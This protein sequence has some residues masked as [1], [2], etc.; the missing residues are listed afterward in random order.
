M[1]KERK[2]I[3]IDTDLGADCDD[4]VALAL[5]I[6]LHK[7]NVLNVK[8]ITISSTREF[9]P[10]TLSAI[11]DYY[12][13][14]CP[15]GQMGLP[16]IDV[17]KDD[18]YCFH[19]KDRLLK[20]EIEDSVKLLRKTLVESKDKVIIATLGPLTNIARL[21][22]SSGDELSPL[23]GL[24]LINSK[25]ESIYIMGGAFANNLP[26]WNLKSD[27][28]S[29]ELVLKSVNVPLFFLPSECG[30]H[31]K[32]GISLLKQI[33]SPV[34][35]SIKSF[36]ESNGRVD[37]FSR[38]S[39]DPLT[40]LSITG[41]KNINVNK[42]GIVSIDSDGVTTL[43]EGEGEHHILEVINGKETE[44][45]INDHILLKVRGKSFMKNE[46]T[47]S[48]KE[49]EIQKRNNAKVLSI[50]FPSDIDKNDA[51]NNYIT[52][53]NINKIYDNDV[54]AVFDF[55]LNINKNEFIVL[56]GPSGCG[57]ST[58]LRMIAGLEEISSGE[59]FINSVY[60]NDLA[61]KNRDIAMVFQTYALYPHMTVYNNLAFGIKIRKF[62][63]PVLDKEGHEVLWIDKREIKKINKQ[64]KDCNEIEKIC[65][66]E[67]EKLK[68]IEGDEDDKYIANKRINYYEKQKSLAEQK[69]ESLEKD[70][71]KAETTMVPKCVYKHLKK[72]EID[73]RVLEAAKILEID[74]YLNRKPKAL[75]GGQRQRV[76]LGRA[77]VRNSAA[78][79]MDEPLS[80]LDAKLRVQ[81]R[82]EI[83]N[84][85]R[86]VGATTIYVTHDQTEAMTMAD[87]IVVMKDGMV[88]QI[89]TPIDIYSHPKNLFVA[90]FIGAPAMNVIEG[91]FNGKEVAFD[92]N[93]QELKNI[94]GKVEEYY[95]AEIARLN[96]V[97]NDME[98]M[99]RDKKHPRRQIFEMARDEA[100]SLINNYQNKIDTMSFDV[101]LGIRPEDVVVVDKKK[102]NVFE[103]K[104][105]MVELLGSEY[106]IH[107]TFAG[108]KFI[109]KTSNDRVIK[110]GDD[111]LIEFKSEKI[112]LFD[113]DSKMSIF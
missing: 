24:E 54:Q 2:N 63:T 71:E 59:L 60:S 87:R 31:I 55:N 9:A 99:L 110:T 50:I 61:A 82:S 100:I 42:K 106:F 39:W 102:E 108:Q 70:L 3:I 111:V 14:D 85:H 64:I 78:F 56:V 79:L 29:A 105:D 11:M 53:K 44:K 48:K 90:Q 36:Y 52:L 93:K 98:E 37:E 112:H 97:K 88:Q 49:L 86:K 91:Q 21:I 27:I 19:F 25:V 38:E 16:A 113:L 65:D 41:Y 4:C 73:K 40:I 23:N 69:R 34:Y 47:I 32:T 1:I 84:I 20:R 76:A 104:A 103:V 57:K 12:H 26:E 28:R 94:K 109:F 6:N 75:S 58:T 96:N 51:G 22:N 13:F 74:G 35:Q 92:S 80:N 101:L 68:A 89:G 95:K 17:D 77:I 67:I 18:H 107:T 72:E 5:A 45:Y 46:T 66:K 43:K 8:A 10:H 62:L 33:D 7:D 30:K 81:M 83:V 15:I